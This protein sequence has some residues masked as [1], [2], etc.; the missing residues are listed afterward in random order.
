MSISS[1]KDC[2]SGFI[3]DLKKHGIDFVISQD[4]LGCQITEIYITEA[5][6]LILFPSKRLEASTLCWV[7]K[8]RTPLKIR[9][10]FFSSEPT[11]FK[12]QLMRAIAELKQNGLEIPKVEHAISIQELS[13]ANLHRFID[14]LENWFHIKTNGRPLPFHRVSKSSSLLNNKQDDSI[15]EKQKDLYIHLRNAIKTYWTERYF[16]K[17]LN[18]PSEN[19]KEIAKRIGIQR[20]VCGKEILYFFDRSKALGKY[21]DHIIKG[22]LKELNLRFQESSKHVFYIP[23]L[24]LGLHFFDGKKE[25]LKILAGE[26]ANNHDLIMIVPEKIRKKIGRIQDDFFEVLPLNQEKIKGTL[27]KLVR[28]RIDYI[29]AYSSG[30]TN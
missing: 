17:Y 8:I 7:L 25:Q 20:E 13:A 14:S 1:S 24:R 19:V 21:F 3:K 22:I 23:D 16:S 27:I 15:S 9:L 30:I 29:P 28:Q 18:I 12:L 10:T 5:K 2:I 4:A 6:E 26:Y 11:E